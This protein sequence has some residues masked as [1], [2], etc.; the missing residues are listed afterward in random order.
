MSFWTRFTEHCS[1]GCCGTCFFLKRRTNK[2]EKSKLQRQPPPIYRLLPPDLSSSFLFQRLLAEKERDVK[3]GV[4]QPLDLDLSGF[5]PGS[6]ISSKQLR[7]GVPLSSVTN[8]TGAWDACV[9]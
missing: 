4:W 8:Q 6:R 1:G 9:Y 3:E 2:Q 5:D 7:L